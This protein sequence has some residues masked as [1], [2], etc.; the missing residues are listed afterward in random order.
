MITGR[1]RFFDVGFKF[2]VRRIN[3][4][5]R[6]NSLRLASIELDQGNKKN[7]R[8]NEILLEN[9]ILKNNEYYLFTL[10]NL[11]YTK[12]VRALIKSNQL[13]NARELIKEYLR[14]FSDIK[15][16]NNSK[17]ITLLLEVHTKMK[18]DKLI[19]KD[20]E[21][22]LEQYLNDFSI[23]NLVGLLKLF[24]ELKQ[25]SQ[26][27]AIFSILTSKNVSN[28]IFF[29]NLM[30]NAVT[31]SKDASGL[32]Q[33]MAKDNIQ[34]NK[35]TFFH[36]IKIYEAEDNFEELKKLF[37]L[38]KLE[39]NSLDSIEFLETFLLS[40]TNVK[41][42]SRAYLDSVYFKILKYLEDCE[43]HYFSD[44]LFA[45]LLRGFALMKEFPYC[46]ILFE[47]ANTS[48][49]ACNELYLSMIFATI[50]CEKEVS[51]A[52]SI[53]QIFQTEP[54]ADPQALSEAHSLIIH[55]AC[56]ASAL[57]GYSLIQQM[58]SDEISPEDHVWEL[59]INALMNDST[60]HLKKVLNLLY[61]AFNA[62]VVPSKDLLED[63]I[64]Y[65]AKNAQHDRAAGLVQFM[66]QHNI[67]VSRAS[68]DVLNHR[69]SSIL[70]DDSD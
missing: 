34:P 30:L 9:D 64:Q 58:L 45:Y 42:T 17:I 44:K 67:P 53:L 8:G 4:Y 54:F 60:D 21:E 40:F 43:T 24:S 48:E 41:N 62:Q 18:E 68:L 51:L 69:I 61:Q 28:S 49:R 1:R 6:S 36:L 57:L 50:N 63:V 14:K 39:K 37:E 2:F 3:L 35:Q 65:C 47:M 52:L 11:Y 66:H 15:N 55:K 7:T 38:F 27:Q 33:Q 25:F 56:Q 22:I 23:E 5:Q 26:C 16:V 29:L 31:T 32:I 12:Q 70:P 59:V 46:V 13:K 20:F 19:K 10:N